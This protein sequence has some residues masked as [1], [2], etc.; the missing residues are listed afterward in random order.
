MN[1]IEV[2]FVVYRFEI[3]FYLTIAAL[4]YV[5]EEDDSR[6]WFQFRVK[7]MHAGHNVILF[8]DSSKISFRFVIE[9]LFVSKKNFFLDR[10]TKR[11]EKSRSLR[12]MPVE[13]ICTFFEFSPDLEQIFLSF[14][15]PFKGI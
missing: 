8:D 11:I 6:Q 13:N 12:T 14:S 1:Q 2:I 4:I 3:A 10:Y 5:H 7:S 9:I 15:S